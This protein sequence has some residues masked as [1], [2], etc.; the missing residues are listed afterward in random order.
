MEVNESRETK[1][2]ETEISWK[3]KNVVMAIAGET[4]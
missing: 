3:M 4:H 1:C 2:E